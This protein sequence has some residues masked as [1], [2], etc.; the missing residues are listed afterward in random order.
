[1]AITFT[2]YNKQQFNELNGT[3]V[4][5]F[6][7]NDLYLSLHTSTYTPDAE[8]HDFYNDVTNEV[9]GTNYSAGGVKLTTVSLTR[10][11]T[12]VTLDADDVTWTQHAAGFSNARYGVLRMSTGNAATSPL[13]GYINFGADV[14]NTAADMV[15]KWNAS[16]ISTWTIS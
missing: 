9:S 3:S 15:V 8:N 14:G 11:T 2:A 10:S 1:M 6:D 7:T 12:T 13:I 5:D 16:G 4:I